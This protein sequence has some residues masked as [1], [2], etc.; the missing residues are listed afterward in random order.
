M[1]KTT[2]LCSDGVI[3][4]RCIL[5]L[6]ENVGE[7]AAVWTSTCIF[8][9]C[10]FDLSQANLNDANLDKMNPADIPDVVSLVAIIGQK[11]P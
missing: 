2:S 10:R 5:S 7:N 8:F 9:V 6:G 3:V 1:P 4:H 11:V